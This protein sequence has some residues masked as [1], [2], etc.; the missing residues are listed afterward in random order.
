M[1]INGTIFTVDLM[2]I[3]VELRRQLAENGIKRFAKIND[4]GDDIMVC[5]PFHKDGQ[6]SKPSMGIRKAD[7]VSHCLACDETMG[8]DR[9]IARCFG[10]ED[11]N[12]GYHW[13]TQNFL[14]VGVSDRVAIEINVARANVADKNTVLGYNNPNQPLLAVSEEELDSY[15]YTHEYLY[16]RGL[17]DSIIE[18]FD[19]GYDPVR[20]DITFPVKGIEGTCLFVARRAVGSKRFDIP[21]G[22][23]KPLYGLY[24]CIHALE[25]KYGKRST[26]PEPVCVCEGLFDCLRLWCNG[27]LAVAGFGCLFSDYQMSQLKA[28][29]TRQLILGLDNDDAG[30]A[31]AVKIRRAVRNKLIDEFVIPSGK[32]DIGELTDE[33]INNLE[34]VFA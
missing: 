25:E 33:E 10:Y 34:V 3:L 28:L 2:D 1:L 11:R 14:S 30:R 21:K 29:P 19:L 32:K 8:L 4:C 7:G 5:C 16:K 26:Y 22:I 15:R 31:G 17:N 12:W 6:E 24:E 20:G 18:L 9:L 27:K 13:L 23:E